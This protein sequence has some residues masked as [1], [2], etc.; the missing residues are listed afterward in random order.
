MWRIRNDD[1]WETID[2]DHLQGLEREREALSRERDSQAQ[3][4]RLVAENAALRTTVSTQQHEIE[5]LLARISEL[6]AASN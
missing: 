3:V 1:G 4:T 5:C 6:K 2:Q